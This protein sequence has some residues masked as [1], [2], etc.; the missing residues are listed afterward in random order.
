MRTFCSGLSLCG[1]PGLLNAHTHIVAK[2]HVY[3][4]MYVV[5]EHVSCMYH[6]LI[7]VVSPV[8]RAQHGVYHSFY[9]HIHDDAYVC[10]A[11]RGTQPVHPY[12]STHV[13]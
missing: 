3:V 12:N 11:R 8:A 7:G 4:C 13:H 5:R 9:V 1:V 6:A 2:P 10:V